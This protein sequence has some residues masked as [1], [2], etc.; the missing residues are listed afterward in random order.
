MPNTTITE[1]LRGSLRAVFQLKVFKRIV[2]QNM[3]ILS[4]FTQP[5]VVLN[6]YN[7]SFYRETKIDAL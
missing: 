1:I 3:T 4:L 7:Y 5:N 6:L 2:Y